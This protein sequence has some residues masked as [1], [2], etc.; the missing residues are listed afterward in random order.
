MESESESPLKFIFLPFPTP[1]HML[2]MADL[3]ITLASHGVECHII[4]TPGNAHIFQTSGNNPPMTVHTLNLQRP[5]VGPDA[6]VENFRSA[7]SNE[8]RANLYHAISMLRKPTEDLIKELLPLDCIISDMFFPW[9]S[10]LALEIQVPRVI[11]HSSIFNTCCAYSVTLHYAPHEL[12]EKDDDTLLIPSLPHKIEMKK[13]Q[14]PQWVRVPSQYTRLIEAVREAELKCYG[15]LSNTFCDEEK[16]YEEY[17]YKLTG[18]KIWNIGPYCLRVNRKEEN[19]ESSYWMDCLKWLDQKKPNSVLY[20][21]FGSLT[22]FPDDQLREIAAG[23]EASGHDFIWVVRKKKEE[24]TME[25]DN[26]GY[27]ST[28]EFRKKVEKSNKGLIIEDW[29]PQLSI[30]E[31][32]AIGGMVTHCG[33]NSILE[34][35]SIGGIPL[36]S[37]PLFAEQFYNERLVVDVLKIGVAVGVTVWYNVDEAGKEIISR[38][39]VELAVRLLMDDGEGAAEMKRR[40]KELSEAARKSVQSGGSSQTNLIAFLDELRTKTRSKVV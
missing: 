5:S 39:K 11:H 9:T 33:W 17:Y 7:T 35:V 37:W 2:Y 38:E 3:A 4:T 12:V 22:R 1:G 6:G 25:E 8:M 27:F 28:E 23:L 20:V 19:A 18:L 21:S 32:Q 30:L 31:H 15:V 34:A 10:D 26:E 40:A 24:E 36:I 16:E 13:S 14:L 29:A